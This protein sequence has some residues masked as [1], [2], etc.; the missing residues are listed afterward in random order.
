MDIKV[1]SNCFRPETHVAGTV[2]NGWAFVRFLTVFLESGPGS[3]V[4]EKPLP[5]APPEVRTDLRVPLGFLEA[6]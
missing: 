6:G 3:E 4:A 2:M 5:R 1:A